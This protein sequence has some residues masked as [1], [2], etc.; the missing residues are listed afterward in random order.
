MEIDFDFE[1]TVMKYCTVWISDLLI[2]HSGLRDFI[3]THLNSI[4]CNI[5]QQCTQNQNLFPKLQRQTCDKIT[6]IVANGYG[7]AS[8]DQGYLPLIRLIGK[9]YSNTD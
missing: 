3:T 5:T 7:K 6:L 1:C 8:L 4:P 2:N 9:I